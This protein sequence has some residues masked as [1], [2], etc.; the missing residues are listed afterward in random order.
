MTSTIVEWAMEEFIH[1]P[2]A[3]DKAQSKLEEVVGRDRRAVI[4]KLPYL[5]AVV[6][7]PHRA[8]QSCEMEI[9]V[10]FKNY[11]LHNEQ[12]LTQ[13]FQALSEA[14]NCMQI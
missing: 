9:P 11:R 12:C 2:E 3:M 14:Y 5:M 7:V 1:N 4:E 6:K 8:D 13:C 10:Y